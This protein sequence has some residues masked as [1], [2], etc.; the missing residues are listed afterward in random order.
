MKNKLSPY[1]MILFSFLGVIIIG[2]LLLLLPISTKTDSNLTFIEAFFTTVSCVCVTGLTVIENVGETMSVFGKIVMAIL[3]QIGGLSFLTLTVF[4]MTAFKVKLGI[5][6]SYLMREQLNQ[7]STKDLEI[8]IG[9]IVKLTLVIEG[10]GVIINTLILYFSKE[11]TFNFGQSLGIG[12]FHTISSFNNAG[13]DIFGTSSSMVGYKA[14]LLLNIST[15]VLV[16]LG[17]LGFVVIID[18]WQK[19]KFKK[20]SLHSKITLT[21][22]L[23]LLVA[24]TILLKISMWDNMTILEAFFMSVSSR[25]AGF[26]SIDLAHISNGCYAVLIVLMFIGASSGSTGGGV[27]TS[28]V[29]VVLDFMFFYFKGKTPRAFYRKI[30]QNI[31][32]KSLALINFCLLFDVIMTLIICMIEQN[33]F[34]FEQILFEQVSAFSTTGLSMGI[35][36]SLSSASKILLC[37][38]MFIGRVG[39][40]TFMGLMNKHWTYESRE[41]IKYVSEDLMIG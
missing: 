20:L 32:L 12:I 19:K 18:V 30:D 38:S 25:T 11:L 27:K 26:S 37:V 10:L 31:L 16:I 40:L 29:F 14:N 24:G 9:R 34:S 39:P 13:F 1:L 35:T 2:T 21:T 15:C 36:K 41:K 28:T 17:G 33:N 3:I 5:S 7:N 22:T 23:V 8:L 6:E 4:F